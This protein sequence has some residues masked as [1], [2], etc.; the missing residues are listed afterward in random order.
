MISTQ[1]PSEARSDSCAGFSIVEL[2]VALLLLGV[3]TSQLFVVLNTQ[4]KAYSDQNDKIDVQDTTRRAL[5]LIT[6]DTRNAGIMIDR[7][8]AIAT[9][10]GDVDAPDRLCLSAS[11]YLDLPDPAGSNLPGSSNAK[12][13]K[14]TNR[15]P[16]VTVTGINGQ[17]V[18]LN[19]LNVDAG[20]PLASASLVD[21]FVGDGVIIA[22]ATTGRSY[23]GRVEAVNGTQLVLENDPGFPNA[24]QTMNPFTGN[25]QAVPAIVYDI[26][27]QAGPPQVF[28][29]R[30]NGF[31]LSRVIE[32]LQVEFWVDISIDGLVDEPAEWPLHTLNQGVPIPTDR[33]R[34]VRIS[35]VGRSDSAESD[36]GPARFKR[37]TAGNRNP[38]TAPD[39]FKR[40]L[41]TA[42]VLPRNM[43]QT[44][45]GQAVP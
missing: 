14:V 24:Q 5:D 8:L 22:D 19:S 30:R 6:Q 43:L 29:L 44:I 9:R 36:T 4:Q 1:S 3:I 11:D 26:D 25:V 39:N 45:P 35:L 15:L 32:D 41:F 34:R 10:D 2:M 17:N 21:F 12:W 42:S 18:D 20:E 28:V 16:G 13:G 27:V 31:E 38:Q 40:Q 7:H 33:V 23:C 37:P